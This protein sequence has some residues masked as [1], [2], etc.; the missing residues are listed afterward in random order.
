MPQQSLL[1]ALR[2]QWLEG[3]PLR[4]RSRALRRGEWFPRRLSLAVRT[5][6]LRLRRAAW[7]YTPQYWLAKKERQTFARAR[8]LESH[9]WKGLKSFEWQA[10]RAIPDFAW[11]EEKQSREPLPLKGRFH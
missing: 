11:A 2:W 4:C 10:F 3:P 9:P 6:P 7:L 8:F 5:F 1:A